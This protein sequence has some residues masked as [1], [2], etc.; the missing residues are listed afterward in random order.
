[1]LLLDDETVRRQ[2]GQ[3][4]RGVAALTPDQLRR[5]D[6]IESVIRVAA[7]VL[8]LVLVAAERISRLVARQDDE[9]YPPRTRTGEEPPLASADRAAPSE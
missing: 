6:R 1:V 4:S 8:D 3:Y 9:Y 2:S 7:P 5:R